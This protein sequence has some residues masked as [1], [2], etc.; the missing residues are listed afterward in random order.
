MAVPPGHFDHIR[1]QRLPEVAPRRT[2]SV[3]PPGP[4]L[5]EDFA[6]HGRRILYKVQNTIQEEIGKRE[7]LGIDPSRLLVLQLSFLHVNERQLLERLG[8]TI[9]E[10]IEKKIAL[11]VPYYT[12]TVAFNT[13]K[14]LEQ[15]LDK[16]VSGCYGI[17]DTERIR[18]SNGD[19]DPLKLTLT[20]LDLEAAK[21]F[22]DDQQITTTYGLEI[23]NKQPQKKSSRTAY[24]LLVQFSD[25]H[26]L[27]NFQ[28]ELE[29]YRQGQMNAGELTANQRRELFDA[30]EDFRGLTRE[31]RMGERIRTE[32]IKGEGPFFFDVDLWFP[33]RSGEHL[34]E[35]ERQ[36]RKV[37]E[38]TGGQVTDSPSV[39]AE[40]MLLTKVQGSLATLETLLNY[41][42]VA[43]VDLPPQFPA[44][45]FSIF[46]DIELPQDT[47]ELPSD[48]P[49]ACVVD[50]GVVAGHP[51]LQGT[52]VD[53]RDFDSGENTPT[54]LVGHG[55]HVAGSVVY[56]DIARCVQSNVWN[57][58]V[59]LL[60]AKVM[61][62][63]QHNDVEF[64]DEQR[65]ETQVRKAILTFAREYGCRIFNLSFGHAFR[66]YRG[67]RQ[68]PWALMLDELARAENIVIIVSAGNVSSPGIP[69]NTRNA[70]IIMKI[71][72]FNHR[73]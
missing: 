50:S 71:K 57:P 47:L 18:A 51:L 1:W 6:R 40:S 69:T 73:W 58:R 46:Q 59:R 5:Q 68:L 64:A 63:G 25:A 28:R 33:G 9:V 66:P 60:S 31:D 35:V 52:V 32:G 16:T 42:R 36:F 17:S 61:R 48:A 15:F 37:V 13:A 49:L 21:R 12:L 44:A 55:T 3:M 20:F 70:V 38:R 24:R 23:R 62:R 8:L 39:V 43:L 22:A 4:P 2:R 11:E 29:M 45:Q 56:G 53:E 41:D 7:D 54:D 14:A 72:R 10:E 30:M 34:R 26:V 19:I 67:G 27:Q 65:V